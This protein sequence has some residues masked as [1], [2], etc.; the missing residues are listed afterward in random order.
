MKAMYL[1]S[2]DDYNY[3]YLH[4]NGQF[5]NCVVNVGGC[6]LVTYKNLKSAQK[7]ANSLNCAYVIEVKIGQVLSEG[8]IIR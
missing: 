4:T 2:N 8:V 5:Y 1:I 3:S 6:K 7:K